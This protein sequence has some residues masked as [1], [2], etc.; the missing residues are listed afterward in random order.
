MSLDS[1]RP[2]RVLVLATTFPAQA[3]DGTPEF[4]LTL[5]AAIAQRGAVVTT[6]A[7]RLP[8]ALSHEVID[9]VEVHRFPYFPRRW[10]GL[11]NGGI[12]PNLRTDRWRWLEVLPLIASFILTTWRQVRSDRPDVIHAH[13]IVPAGLVAAVLRPLTGIPYVVTAHGADA[14]TLRG[15]LSGRVKQLV[16]RRAAANVPVSA[17]I[18][19]QLAVLGP[20]TSPVPMGVDVARIRSEVGQRRPEPGRVLF[21][22]R[23]VEKKGV[24]LMLEAA[25]RLPDATAVIVG[26]GPLRGKLGDLASQLGLSDRTEFLGQLPRLEVMS[27]MARA[28]ILVV[29]SQVGAGGDQDGVPVVLGEA[30]AAGVPIVASD[31]GGL[32]E[33]VEDGVNGLVV[34]SGD[35]QA[36]SVALRRLLDDPAFG[37]ALATRSQSDMAST[38]DISEVSRRY[39]QIMSIAARRSE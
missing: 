18:G 28:A 23:L 13:W 25:A 8:G 33:H 14:Y 6:I 7:P 38:L 39:L 34:S 1:G 31:I 11:A 26:D 4:V 15:R 22:G 29:P 35:S 37:E 5:S 2:L 19:A 24:D 27:Q 21:V 17:A 10:E 9:G 30:M 36:L 12:M 3:G 20:V 32:G 16:L